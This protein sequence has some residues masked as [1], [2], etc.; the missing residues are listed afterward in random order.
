MACKTKHK[1]GCAASAS[2]STEHRNTAS[3]SRK[4]KKKKIEDKISRANAKQNSLGPTL[5][6]HTSQENWIWIQNQSMYILCE[7]KYRI[8]AFPNDIVEPFTIS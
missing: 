5:Y 8:Q 6:K 2:I 7:F 3:I 4:G 1:E